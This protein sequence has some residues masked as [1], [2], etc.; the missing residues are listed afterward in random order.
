[1]LTTPRLILRPWRE[2]DQ[3]P[4]ADIT[5]DPEVM[6]FFNLVRTRAQSDAWMARAQA[7]IER[8]GFGIWAVE[9]PGV[10]PLIGFVGL[11]TVPAEIPCAPAVEAVWTLGRPWWRRGYCS[12]AAAAAVADGF[13][14][15][16][17]PDIVAFTAALNTPSQAVM[18]KIGMT[19]DPLGDF[20]CPRVAEG[21]KLQPHVL[22]RIK[23]PA[24]ARA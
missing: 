9:A 15:L 1:M 14:R 5:A 23:N 20:D 6:R 16:G 24:G 21:H 13:T 17:L 8:T 2:S 4:L 10:A 11:S 7:H 3:A 19:R 12:E 22:Y 18:R